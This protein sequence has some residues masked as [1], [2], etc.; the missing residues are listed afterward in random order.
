MKILIDAFGG[1]NSP[2]AVIEGTVDALK[3]NKDFTAVLVGDKE[4]LD[5]LLKEFDYD[6]SRVEILHGDGLRFDGSHNGPPYFVLCCFYY[7]SKY[8]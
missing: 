1:D 5:S 6:K 3:E 7:R 8:M 4:K 2:K